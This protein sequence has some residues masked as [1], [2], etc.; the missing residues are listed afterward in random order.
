MFFKIVIVDKNPKPQCILTF[1]CPNR[2]APLLPQTKEM[3]LKFNSTPP[4]KFPCGKASTGIPEMICFQ[5]FIRDSFLEE[6]TIH[7]TPVFRPPS[8]SLSPI[9]SSSNF[10]STRF[11]SL[12]FFFSKFFS[13]SPISF[14]TFPLSFHL[15]SVHFLSLY[16]S[17]CLS[18]HFSFSL[19]LSFPQILTSSKSAGITLLYSLLLSFLPLRLFVFLS[20]ILS[21]SCSSR[22]AKQK[23]Q[24]K[25]NP[26][27]IANLSKVGVSPHS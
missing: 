1:F 8:L 19:H 2:V 6:E 16:V 25:D 15:S 14:L 5:N 23:C 9:S 12:L 26:H 11:F 3:E 22:D 17:L 27:E 20:Y 18:L 4:A 7:V 13:L 21:H 10:W 24:S